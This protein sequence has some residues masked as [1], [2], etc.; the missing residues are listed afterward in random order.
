MKRSLSGVALKIIAVVAMT[1]DHFAWLYIPLASTS[2]QL[3]HLVGRMTAPLMAFLVAEGYYYSKN[4][5]RYVLR[6]AVF[7]V[8]SHL[9]FTYYATGTLTF[10]APTSVLFTILLGLLALIIAR[11]DALHWAVKLLCLAGIFALS[12]LGDWSFFMVLWILAFGIFHDRRDLALIC[13]IF[14]VLL[15]F[16]HAA[17]NLQLM[18]LK[19]LIYCFGGML[20]VPLILLYNDKPGKPRMQYFFYLYYPLH[21]ILIRFVYNTGFLR[22]F[23]WRP[24]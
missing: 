24:H 15:V 23:F 17:W 20:I 7:A 13:H 21:L 1:L 8:L 5:P 9:P 14:I 16:V 10:F 6:L 18:M 4:L 3:L 19:Y 22:D 2:G 12:M 11:H